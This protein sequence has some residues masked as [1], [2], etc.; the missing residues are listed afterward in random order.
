MTRAVGARL[1]YGVDGGSEFWFG[2]LPAVLSHSDFEVRPHRC[3][4]SF[5]RVLI[6]LRQ[7]KGQW[8]WRVTGLSFVADGYSAGVRRVCAVY[9]EQPIGSNTLKFHVRY[10]AQVDI[11]SA[12]WQRQGRTRVSVDAFGLFSLESRTWLLYR[13]SEK[14]V[15]EVLRTDELATITPLI[16]EA[17]GVRT[18]TSDVSCV[19][20]ILYST[21]KRAQQQELL[22]VH[23][24][25]PALLSS[26]AAIG[27]KLLVTD[28]FGKTITTKVFR[29][30]EFEATP[31]SATVSSSTKL[32][33]STK[34][35]P[36]AWDIAPSP[37]D[38]RKNLLLI[39]A[40]ANCQVRR[41]SL[42][43]LFSA[44][45]HFALRL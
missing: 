38:L 42:L 41:I 43:S 36:L 1:K 40:G 23:D 3:C 45:A 13:S 20:R 35:S 34:A 7:V 17:G 19:R 14:G 4:C 2:E 26:T 15:A 16:E 8:D 25:H 37:I 33:S 32:Q 24:L 22:I 21:H 30:Y 9:T 11:D 44:M 5:V 6:V 10:E 29:K 18:I 31:S 39:S 27:A 28:V 12:L